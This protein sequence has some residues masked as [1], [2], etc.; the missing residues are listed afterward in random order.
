MAEIARKIGRHRS[1]VGRELKRNADGRSGH[2]R[3]ELAQ[4]KAVARHKG[5]NKHRAFTP[6]VRDL[7][8]EKLKKDYSPEQI[9]GRAD[10][11][12]V[13]CVSPER[14]YQFVWRDK[15]KGGQ[16]YLYLRTKGRKYRK[17]GSKK[18]GRGHIVILPIVWTIFG[19]FLV[20]FMPH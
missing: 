3:A 16:L 11:D 10:L 12:N 13:A 20:C 15:K 1:T 6:A 8:T 19:H 2:Y 4:K 14:I 5:K 18:A 7:V 17:R 9:K